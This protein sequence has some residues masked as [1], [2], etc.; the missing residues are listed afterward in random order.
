MPS[1]TAQDDVAVNTDTDSI[2]FNVVVV[3]ENATA[4]GGMRTSTRIFDQNNK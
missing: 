4:G 3:V 2:H 1:S